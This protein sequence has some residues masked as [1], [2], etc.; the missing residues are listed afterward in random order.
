VA[1]GLAVGVVP[2]LG[3]LVTTGVAVSWGLAV[4]A[5]LDVGA[6]LAVVVEPGLVVGGTGLEQPRSMTTASIA[7]IR[8]RILASVPPQRL[9]SAPIAGT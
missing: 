6:G 2:G 9:R 3:V 8:G 4:G 1:N 5:A 7:A